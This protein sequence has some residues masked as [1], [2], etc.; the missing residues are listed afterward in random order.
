MK[1]MSDD[2]YSQLTG[3]DSTSIEDLIQR[4]KLSV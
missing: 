3:L 1:W 2:E 4:G